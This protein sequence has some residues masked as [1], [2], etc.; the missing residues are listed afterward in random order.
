MYEKYMFEKPEP[1]P[2]E[3]LERLN[4]IKRRIK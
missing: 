3:V 4:N 2:K 1:V